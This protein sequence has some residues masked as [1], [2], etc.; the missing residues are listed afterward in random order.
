MQN[1]WNWYYINTLFYLDVEWLLILNLKERLITQLLILN[2]FHNNYYI[3]IIT[4]ISQFHIKI[5]LDSCLNTW[6]NECFSWL[7]K[8]LTDVTRKFNCFGLSIS[9]DLVTSS[10]LF[11]QC[12]IYARIIFILYWKR[13]GY[14]W[15]NITILFPILPFFLLLY[16]AFRPGCDDT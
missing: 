1:L 14:G 3:I 8:F 2:I 13:K 10:T 9:K 7:I 11:S 5:Q 6:V 4:F 16:C 15:I 12:I